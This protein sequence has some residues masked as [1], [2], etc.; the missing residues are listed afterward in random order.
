MKYFFLTLKKDRKIN[1]RKQKLKWY[2][3]SHL[4]KKQINT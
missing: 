1:K 4:N 2:E 3:I